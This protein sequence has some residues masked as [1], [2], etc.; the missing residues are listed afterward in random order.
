MASGT[1]TAT[2]GEVSMVDCPKDG[3]L[4][5][6]FTLPN[7]FVGDKKYND[8]GAKHTQCFLEGAWKGDALVARKDGMSLADPLCGA[9]RA[10]MSSDFCG[11]TVGPTATVT[12]TRTNTPTGMVATPTRTATGPT[13]T[14]TRTLVSTVTA[15]RTPSGVR[16][17]TATVTGRAT[18][19]A[20]TP[21]I[22]PG[23][24][25]GFHGS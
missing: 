7:N 3:C 24:A 8:F 2:V 4:G 20:T 25:A 6:A 9:P 15:T 21:T 22:T 18:P 16:T 10:A 12:A 17:P 23:G 11:G 14:S 19:T 13:P 5:F 1:T